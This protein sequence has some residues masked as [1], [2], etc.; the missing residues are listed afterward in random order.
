MI[1][2]RVIIVSY[3]C[4]GQCGS[5]ICQHGTLRLVNGTTS[6]QGR[7][8]ICIYSVWGTVCSYAFDTNDARV[9]CRQLGYEVDNGQSTCK[10]H[11]ST[12]FNV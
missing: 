3:F 1:S 4:I 7:L 6:N 12:D 10:L 2:K 11:Q 5:S 8:E 9:A